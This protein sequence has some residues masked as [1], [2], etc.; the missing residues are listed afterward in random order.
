M[1]RLTDT[2][3]QR[4]MPPARIV[5]DTGVKGFGVRISNGGTKSFVVD[6]RRR[7]DGLQRR[8][9][10][11]SY[12]DWCTASAREQAK[13]VK[14]DVDLG[15]D[16]VG[17]QAAQRAAPTVA[18]LCIRFDEEHIAKLAPHT[19]QDYRAMLK[20]DILPVLGKL[21]VASVEFSHIERL[22]T[23]ISRRAPVLANRVYQ[24][25]SKMLALAVMWKLRADNP[26][27]GV[28]RN[29]EHL[30]RRYLKPDE[31]ARL[32]KALAEDRNQRVADVFRLLLLT[33]ARKGEVL[34]ATWDQFDL[35]AGVW[36]KPPA[37][38]K[39]RRE[40]IVPLNAPAR[41]LIARLQAQRGG[42][43]WL[44]PG[45]EGGKL[46]EDLT[47]AW[48]R[49]CRAAGII[50]LRI[51]D[52]RHSHASFLVS[53]GFSLPTIGALLGHTSPETTARYAHLLDDPLR[54][55]VERV[56]GIVAPG[57][58]AEIVPLLRRQS[59]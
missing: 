1:P 28:K 11:G 46:C 53:A 15:A 26:C 27:R 25:V 6:Y 51:H 3:V 56:G 5:W 17:E 48:Q 23:T 45:R 19:Q 57:G 41:Q 7:A 54:Q 59:E 22:H 4:L 12:P 37:S 21:K 52:L 43:P 8:Y 34:S 14:R 30:R 32:T 24:V 16:P 50:G 36:T 18:E 55:A 39:Q 42:S 29:R 20:N 49:V 40:H 33:G 9:T 47:Y 2:T 10:I 31:L 44:F 13:R 58:S 38:T 35:T